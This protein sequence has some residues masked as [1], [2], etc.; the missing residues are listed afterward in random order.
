M[1]IQT[2]QLT[3]KCLTFDCGR[4]LEPI[5][6]E[7]RCSRKEMFRH[8]NKSVMSMMIMTLQLMMGRGDCRHR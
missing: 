7:H 6:N 2:S 1:S 8:L 4:K 3:L 5:G